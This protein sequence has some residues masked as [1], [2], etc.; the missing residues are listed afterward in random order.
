VVGTN[1]VRVTA[2]LAAAAADRIACTPVAEIPTGAT[3]A[4]AVLG[5]EGLA[6]LASFAGMAIL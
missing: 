4:L 5:R 6:D 2:R 3:D 1:P